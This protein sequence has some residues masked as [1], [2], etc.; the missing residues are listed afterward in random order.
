M[1]LDS[2][3]F[4]VLELLLLFRDLA[5]LGKMPKMLIKIIRAKQAMVSSEDDRTVVTT[6]CLD[7]RLNLESLL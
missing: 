5:G 3:S 1:L 7:R 4:T 2:N 6:L